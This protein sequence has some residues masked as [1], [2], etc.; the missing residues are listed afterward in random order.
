MNQIDIMS[1]INL[2]IVAVCFLVGYVIKNYIK[3]IPNK[4]IPLIMI[5]IGIIVSISI[6]TLSSNMDIT[7]SIISGAISG[8]AST[9][10]YEFIVNTFGLKTNK[11]TA[12]DNN[13]NIKDTE[14]LLDIE[15]PN[16]QEDEILEQ[17]NEDEQYSDDN[18]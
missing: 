7:K 3:K 6:S 14:D 15:T 17:L 12:N 13:I 4:Y 16:Y 5:G 11:D 10:S 18:T 9:G 1:F 8:L 2:P